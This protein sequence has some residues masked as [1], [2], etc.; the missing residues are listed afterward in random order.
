MSI[1]VLVDGRQNQI[2]PLRLCTSGRKQVTAE[3]DAG[4]SI[5]AHVIQLHRDNLQLWSYKI[6]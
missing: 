3:R 2:N 1:R 5:F 4:S 6:I